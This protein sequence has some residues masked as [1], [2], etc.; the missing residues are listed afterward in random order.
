MDNI[1]DIRSAND[2][3]DLDTLLKDF[4]QTSGEGL[5]SP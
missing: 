2:A 1:Q 5:P 3:E 4:D